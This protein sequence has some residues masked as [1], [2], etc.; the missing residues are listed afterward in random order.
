MAPLH[1]RFS[2]RHLL[3]A[4]VPLLA[5]CASTGT[6]APAAGPAVAIPAAWHAAPAPSA[7]PQDLARWWLQLGDPLLVALVD[8]AVARNPDLASSRASLREARARLRA[9]GAERLPSLDASAAS[10]TTKA[11]TADSNANVSAGLDARW[12]LDL[13]GAQ[14]LGVEAAEADLARSAALLDSAHA[15]LAAEVALDYVALRSAQ[16]RL[17]IARSNLA[18]QD[19]TLQLTLWRVEAG[20]AS[21]V[22]LA[23]ARSGR[24]QTAATIPA[25]Q[26]AEAAAAHALAALTAADTGALTTRLAGPA[27]L[28]AVPDAITAGIPADT[29][30]RRPDVRAATQAVLAESARSDAARVARY[31]SLSLSASLGSEALTLG[32][33]GG[34]ATL[35]RSLVAALGASLFDGGRLDAQYD[36][37]QAIRDQALASLEATLLGALRETEDALVAFARNGERELTLARALAAAREAAALARQRY[38][39]GLIDFQTV[40]DTE[41]TLRGVE[42]S[43]AVARADRLTSLIQ[44]YKALGGGWSRPEANTPRSPA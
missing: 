5:A 23:Q 2:A 33:L 36:A 18:G 41:R 30:G 43:R 7:E 22:D 42:D 13:F 15:S 20:L 27:A 19:E 39:G 14:R 1:P 16:A 6:S 37:R 29:L 10:G 17:A 24:E 44:L 32:A 34:A 3:V 26:A 12:E 25:L 9:A 21:A 28:P 38:Q 40:L 8:E 31:P 35:S 11:G 4:V